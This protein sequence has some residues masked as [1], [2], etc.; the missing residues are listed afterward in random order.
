MNQV[1]H[2]TEAFVT[3][4]LLRAVALLLL[5]CVGLGVQAQSAIPAKSDKLVND[6]GNMLSAGEESALTQKLNQYAKETSTQIA[7]VTEQSL[8]GYTAFDRS[9]EIAQGWG[10][11][12]SERTDNGILMY[13][14]RDDRRIQIQTGYGTEGFLPDALA[15]RIIDQI[16]T[17]AFRQ[18][19]IYQGIDEATGAIMSLGK[20]EYTADDI[21]QE[22]EG[23]PP[24]LIFIGI[25]LIFMAL[26]YF[27][28]RDDDDDDDGGYWRKGSYDMDDPNKQ[29]RRRRRRGGGF[30][31]LPGGFG[32]GGGGGFGGG[33]GGGFG[34]FGGGG[35]GGG[36]AG[37][38]W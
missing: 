37:G 11:G 18:G 16:M 35:F 8:N 9:I 2:Y 29:V 21:K 15:K 13:I 26:S 19:Q 22:Q 31:F 20:G 5:L 32:G 36:G 25:F 6:F 27:N 28:R 30:I 14:A 1:R 7:I 4:A 33:G 3:P 10:I 23:F 24:I 38:G 34:G 12:G 17:P